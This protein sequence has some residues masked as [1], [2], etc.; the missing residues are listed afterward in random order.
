MPESGFGG[1]QSGRQGEGEGE[2]HARCAAVG[3]GR[4]QR[5]SRNWEG[6]DD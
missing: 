5:E 6:N 2:E 1:E 4:W 3:A